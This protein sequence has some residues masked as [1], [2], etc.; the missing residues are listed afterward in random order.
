[1]LVLYFN[2]HVRKRGTL[3]HGFGGKFNPDQ[4]GSQL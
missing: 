3:F 1:M 4:V 2:L